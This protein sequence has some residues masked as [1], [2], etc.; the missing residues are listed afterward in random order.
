MFRLFGR[1][2]EKAITKCS[3]KV[4]PVN[5]MG[6]SFEKMMKNKSLTNRTLDPDSP[7]ES[8]KKTLEEAEQHRK[9][10]SPYSG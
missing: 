9:R 5:N 10:Y 6:P 4:K 3:K 8:F 7:G 2:A 1:Q